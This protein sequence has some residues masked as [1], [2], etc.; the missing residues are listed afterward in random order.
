MININ[1]KFKAFRFLQLIS[2]TAFINFITPIFSFLNP[3]HFHIIQFL[4]LDHALLLY[5]YQSFQSIL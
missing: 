5:I 2:F 1:L 3:L 4:I